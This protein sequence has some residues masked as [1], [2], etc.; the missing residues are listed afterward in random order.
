MSTAT[1]LIIIGGCVLG[2]IL[3]L[4]IAGRISSG[5]RSKK[6]QDNI[7]K[8]NSEK[9]KIENEVKVTLPSESEEILENYQTVG[10][11]IVEDYIPEVEG[12]SLDVQPEPAFDPFDLNSFQMNEPQTQ[13]IQTMTKDDDFEK[14]MNEHSYSRKVFNTSLVEKIKK[15]P[16]DVRI[17]LLSNVFDRF[18]DEK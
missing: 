15:L 16:K 6:L 13:P 17:L 14:F 12:E 7:K 11:P 4:I 5:R 8:L 10:Q 18:D 9:E 1:L 3:V 2:L